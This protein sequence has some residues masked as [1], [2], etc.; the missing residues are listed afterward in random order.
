MPKKD[1][2]LVTIIG[3]AVG[4]LIQPMLTTIGGSVPFVGAAPTITFRVITFIVF[5][6][7]APFTL[8]IAR[9]VSR[10]V[11]FIYQFAKYAAVGTLNSFIDFGVLNL[12]MAATGFTGGVPFRAFK[13]FSFLCAT[14]NSFAWNSVW[15]FE[16]KQ[17][18]KKEAAKFYAV[19]IIGWVL[20]VA[21]ASFVRDGVPIPL[22][23][24]P[25]LW[26]NVAALAGILATF[27][28][29][30]LGYKFFVFRSSPIPNP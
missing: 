1:L 18:T 5:L 10:F 4:L 12:L 27:L 25:A 23:I 13:A 14:T 16:A 7:L 30:F 20:N 2:L 22:D 29:N 28:W 26:A 19:A 17:R 24:A 8:A 3:A 6:L 15:T 21:V 9:F 11:P